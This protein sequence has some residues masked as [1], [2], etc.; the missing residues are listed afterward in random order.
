MDRAGGRR[1]VIPSKKN[2]HQQREIDEELY[3]DRNKV[4]RFFNR[5]KHYRRLATRYEKTALSYAAFLHVVCIME[6]LL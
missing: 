1:S 3:K 6:W 5:I 4:G 2:R